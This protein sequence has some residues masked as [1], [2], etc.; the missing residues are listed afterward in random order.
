MLFHAKKFQGIRFKIGFCSTRPAALFWGCPRDELKFFWGGGGFKA[1]K[2]PLRQQKVP[3][4]TEI[5]L[6]KQTHPPTKEGLSL[7]TP[8]SPLQVT[9]SLQR[10]RK[11]PRKGEGVGMRG[12]DGWVGGAG[13]R[14]P[15][16]GASPSPS[17]GAALDSGA[18]PRRGGGWPGLLEPPARPQGHAG[19]TVSPAL[20][21]AP[22]SAR[23]EPSEA[24]SH[25]D[26]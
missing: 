18:P 17:R 3:F 4:P 1:S 16:C 26:F 15:P 7:P 8:T 24:A 13:D 6:K 22:S 12:G 20:G 25:P 2:R 23:T 14:S 21:T 19:V 11:P 10:G 9:V 5:P